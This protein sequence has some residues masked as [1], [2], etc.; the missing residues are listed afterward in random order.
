MRQALT[1]TVVSGLM[2]LCIV[3]LSGSVHARDEADCRS[4]QPCGDTAVA[5]A[6]VLDTSSRFAE[7]TGGVSAAVRLPREVAVEAVGWL[8]LLGILLA[9]R[10]RKQQAQRIG[11]VAAAPLEE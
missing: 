8:W 3:S 10:A 6:V 7:D 1:K 11:V 4:G 2:A 9:V 5:P